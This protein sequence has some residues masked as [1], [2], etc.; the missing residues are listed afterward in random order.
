MAAAGIVEPVDVL[1]DG[2]LCLPSGLPL[3]PPDQLCLQAFEERLDGGI[4]APIFVKRLLET[5]A[6]D[7]N[8]QRFRGRYNALDSG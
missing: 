5:F 3:V 7:I 2:C 6:G 8:G 4:E 1:E